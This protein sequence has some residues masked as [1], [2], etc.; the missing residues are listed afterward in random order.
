[1]YRCMIVEDQHL[2]KE[3]F[4]SYLK[5]SEEFEHVVTI[6]NASDRKSVV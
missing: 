6:A 3:V 2:I 5:D 4:E 1:M